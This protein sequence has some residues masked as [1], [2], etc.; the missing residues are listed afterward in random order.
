MASGISLISRSCI[1]DTYDFCK[2]DWKEASD[3]TMG[4]VL[5]NV[6]ALV[7]KE[8]KAKVLPRYEDRIPQRQTNHS[9]PEKTGLKRSVTEGRVFRKRESIDKLYSD[10]FGH[11]HADMASVLESLSLK[12]RSCCLSFG[13][14]RLCPRDGLRKE[15]W[16]SGS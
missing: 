10:R 5:V 13:C 4:L 15:N 2:V 11:D 6:S 14:L 16:K 8:A 3:A 12:W 7:R 9:R 1:P